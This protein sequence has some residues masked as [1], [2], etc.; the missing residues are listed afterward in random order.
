MVVKYPEVSAN[1]VAW[2]VRT[3]AALYTVSFRA[4]HVVV[5]AALT[6]FVILSVPTSP[7]GRTLVH[8]G[9]DI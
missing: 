7:P 5:S 2:S 8:F 9:D 1:V 4:C 3:K 6:K